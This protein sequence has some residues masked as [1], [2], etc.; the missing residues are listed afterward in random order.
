LEEKELVNILV[1][2]AGSLLGQGLIKSLRLSKTGYYIIGADPDPR[3]VGLYWSDKAYIIPMATDPAYVQRIETILQREH[4]DA[5]LIGTDVELMTLSTHRSD[6][7]S[8]FGTHVI[9]S[10]PN[11]VDIAND[12]WL[13]YQ[14]LKTNGF[15]Y[16]LSVL[17]P[18]VD[19]LIGSCGFPLVV[20]PRIGARS[21]GTTFVRNRIELDYALRKPEGLMVQEL[22]A[23]PAEEYTSGLLM[24]DGRVCSVVTMRRELRD[25]NTFRAV[26][27]PDS[28]FNPFLREVANAL[29]TTGPIN[30]QFRVAQGI[31]KIFEI[32]ARF[33]GTTPLRGYAGHNEVDCFVRHVVAGDPITEPLLERVAIFRYWEE[34][35]VD[36]DVLASIS[37]IAPSSALPFKQP[38][39]PS[40]RGRSDRQADLLE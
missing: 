21:V 26:V 1:T 12:K 5:V 34:L 25:G 33:S 19:E 4:P 7:E 15:P 35:V 36:P 30:F 37:P 39:H 3:A 38:F 10:P 2:G 32:N 17:P 23:T 16:P 9:V 28:P 40:D 29:Q 22:V 20:K 6:L 24:S 13:T 18:Q 11:V 27:E 31:P 8:R 14:F